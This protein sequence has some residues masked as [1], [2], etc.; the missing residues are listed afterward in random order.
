MD[1]SPLYE[2]ATIDAPTGYFRSAFKPWFHRIAMH[3]GREVIR[4]ELSYLG[5]HFTVLPTHSILRD[6]SQRSGS[7]FDWYAWAE[8]HYLFLVLFLSLEASA[9][10]VICRIAPVVPVVAFIVSAIVSAC[11]YAVGIVSK[12]G[13]FT[14]E[15]PIHIK[16]SSETI[17]ELL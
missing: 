9:I 6:Y 13:A 16:D 8:I 7:H 4:W 12:H 5:K 1:T 14:R 2:T 15:E 11:Y 17:A 10:V 3:K